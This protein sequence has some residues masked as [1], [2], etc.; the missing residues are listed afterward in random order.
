VSVLKYYKQANTTAT[1][2]RNISDRHRKKYATRTE[3]IN[4]IQ[5]HEEGRRYRKVFAANCKLI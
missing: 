4:Q 5:P 2:M 3:A 1:G